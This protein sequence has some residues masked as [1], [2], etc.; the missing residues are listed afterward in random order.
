MTEELLLMKQVRQ[1]LGGL[2]SADSIKRMEREGRF[3]RGRML[4]KR[5]M[6]WLKSEV[7]EWIRNLPVRDLNTEGD[8]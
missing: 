5:K 3:P 1:L 2:L 8:Q 7:E 4:S 6:V